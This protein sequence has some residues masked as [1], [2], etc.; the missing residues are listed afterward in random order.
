MEADWVN[1][2]ELDGG[3]IGYVEA[4]PG[5]ITRLFVL[6]QADGRGIGK[7]LLELGIRTARKD[8]GGPVVVGSLRNAGPSMKG[9][10]LI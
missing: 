3:V 2:A 7:W 8:R 9:G 4:V 5:E 10:D 1:V 6:P